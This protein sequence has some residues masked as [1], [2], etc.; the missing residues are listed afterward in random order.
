MAVN[1]RRTHSRDFKVEAVRK[2]LVDDRSTKDAGAEM[3]VRP[4]LLA[5]W[6][7]EFGEDEA[8]AFPGTVVVPCR[9]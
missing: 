8:E 2:I 4:D 3:G 6:V 7:R 5:R 9:T 1:K